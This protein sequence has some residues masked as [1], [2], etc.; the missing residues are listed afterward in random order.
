MRT[1]GKLPVHAIVSSLN[2]TFINIQR[3]GDNET[4]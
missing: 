1:E 3:E 4:Q 2:V